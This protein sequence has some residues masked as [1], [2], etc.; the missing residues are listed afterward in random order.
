MEQDRYAQN[1]GLFIISMICLL[2]C[3]SLLAFAMYILPALV[4]NWRYDVPEMVIT[5]R[6]SIRSQ[7]GFTETFAGLAVFLLF[8]IPAMIL[9]FISKSTSN[10]IEDHIYGIEHE[11]KVNTEVIKRDVQQTVSFSIKILLLALAVIAAVFFVEWL[12]A[13]PPPTAL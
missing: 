1:K 12:I 7:Y 4:W 8:F 13:R 11:S 10:N 5:M 6:E 9:G 3:L 2:L